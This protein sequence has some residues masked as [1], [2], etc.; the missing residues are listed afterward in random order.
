[1]LGL[2]FYLEEVVSVHER[3]GLHCPAFAENLPELQACVYSQIPKT[4]SL[5][6]GLSFLDTS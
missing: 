2:F 1:M 3:T 4:G 6:R 5:Q